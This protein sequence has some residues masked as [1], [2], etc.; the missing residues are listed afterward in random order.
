MN[1][2]RLMLSNAQVIDCTLRIV[3]HRIERED[4]VNL[5]ERNI[6]AL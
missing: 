4:L 2:Y 1:G 5:V 3:T 6:A